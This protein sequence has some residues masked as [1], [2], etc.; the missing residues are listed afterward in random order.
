CPSAGLAGA[1]GRLV[2]GLRLDAQ[3]G[4]DLV[5]FLPVDLVVVDA[6]DHHAAA[7]DHAALDAVEVG[8]PRQPGQGYRV[9]NPHVRLHVTVDDGERP[10]HVQQGHVGLH[11]PGDVD[12]KLL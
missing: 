7:L 9:A 8:A 2:A 6:V 1:G 11:L 5:G 3:V 4:Q 10:R 12:E